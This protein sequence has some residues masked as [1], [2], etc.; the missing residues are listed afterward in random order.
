M[1]VYSVV[2]AAIVVVGLLGVAIHGAY[3]TRKYGRKAS[4][5]NNGAD[6]GGSNSCEFGG[7]DVGGD[8]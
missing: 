4:H 7:G 8:D 1:T 6:D 5:S 2:L 3:W